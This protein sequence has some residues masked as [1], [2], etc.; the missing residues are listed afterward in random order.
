MPGIPASTLLCAAL[1]AAGLLQACAPAPLYTGSTRVK[2]AATQGEI[3]RD[4]RGEPVWSA[5][6]PPAS[7]EV[8]PAQPAAPRPALPER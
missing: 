5:I 2:G 7:V 1:V 4:A 8:E 6:R 3:P